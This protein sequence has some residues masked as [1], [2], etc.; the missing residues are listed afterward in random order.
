MAW[1]CPILA[2]FLGI[3]HVA[4]I[5]ISSSRVMVFFQLVS[6]GKKDSASILGVSANRVPK[7]VSFN[8]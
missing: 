8:N 4:K 1:L 5:A 3:P 6:S 7:K 2:L